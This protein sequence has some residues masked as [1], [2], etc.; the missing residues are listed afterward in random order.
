MPPPRVLIV[1]NFLSEVVGNR[2][3]CE[4][5]APRLCEAGFSVITT[6]ARKRRV[7]RLLEMLLTCWKHRGS[8]DVAQVDVYSGPSFLW[9]ESVCWILRRLNKPYVL[10]LHGGALPVFARREKQRVTRLLKSAAAVTVPSSYLL[11]EMTAYCK[12]LLLLPNA[13]DL[14]Q[15]RRGIHDPLR[16]RLI[17]LRAFHEIYNPTMAV[18]VLAHLKNEF[19]DICL[20]MVGPDKGGLTLKNVIATARACGVESH[21][22][23]MG[24]VTKSQVPQC[25]ERADIFLNT[26]NF[27]NTPVSVLEAM[28]SGLC[29]VSTNAG[30]IP[31]LLKTEEEALLVPVNDDLAMAAAIRRLLTDERLTRRMQARALAKVEQFDWKVVLPQWQALLKSVAAKIPSPR[32]AEAIP[33]SERIR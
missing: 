21:L 1:G 8:Y 13:L 31:N 10:T 16:P 2:G 3:V 25:L 15:H 11:N 24:H 6:S 12:N 33:I 22:T 14:H 27:D 20:T 4:E 9:A 19:P 18:R 32:P 7:E 28:A 30:G 17:W 29:V 26:S 5:L 23:V